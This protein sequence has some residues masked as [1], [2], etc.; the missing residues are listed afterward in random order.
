MIKRLNP[1]FAL[2]LLTSLS[3]LSFMSTPDSLLGAEPILARTILPDPLPPHPRL[4]VRPDSWELL[5]A[6]LKSD[7]VNARMYRSLELQAEKMLPEPPVQRVLIGRRLLDK[8]RLA[9]ARI[10][11]LSLVYKV[12]GDRRFADRAITEMLACASFTDWNPTHFLDVAEMSLALALGYDWLYAEMDDAQRGRIAGALIQFGLEESF[13]RDHFFI[14]TTNNWNQ[15]CHAGLAAAAIAV[16]DLRP[17]LAEATLRRAIENVPRAAAVYG[18]DGNYPE[19]PMYWGYGTS[20][21]VVLVHALATLTDQTYGLDSAPGFAES[22]EYMRHVTT[23]TAKLYPYFDCGQ[24]RGL[25]YPLYWF[26]A[27]YG[28]PDWATYDEVHLDRYM[29]A[30]DKEP[31]GEHYRLLPLALLWRLEKPTAGATA[32]TTP[33][34]Q[35]GAL[36]AESWMGRGLEP[37][38]LFRTA[39]EDRNALFA[40]IKGGSPGHNHGHMD[41]GSFII[42]AEGIRWALDLGMQDYHSLESIGIN[43]WQREEGGQRW[44]VFRL[45]PES[46]NILRFNG[47]HQAAQGMARLMRFQGAGASRHAVIDLGE[48][49]PEVATEVK[50]G[51]AMLDERVFLFQDEWVAGEGDGVDV[52]WQWM[53]KAEVSTDGNTITLKQDGKHLTLQVLEPPDVVVRVHPAASLQKDYDAPNPGVVRLDVEMSTPAGQPGRLRILA[54]PGNVADYPPPPAIPLEQWPGVVTEER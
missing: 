12:G 28:R 9:L 15:V 23:P 33:A 18:P 26:A 37:V 40:G 30:M 47:K 20:F 2:L 1:I 38:A 21:H 4:A 48:L 3:L 52:T 31:A 16:A 8:S 42:E 53:T 19:G 35:G 14:T 46:H 11:T 36:P 10:S 32:D 5:A 41:A 13:S 54:L 25:A 24:G 50:R 43:M 45:G 7:P 49:Y 51:L 44:Q 34:P 22:A 39:F 6:S 27:H 29:D 17:D